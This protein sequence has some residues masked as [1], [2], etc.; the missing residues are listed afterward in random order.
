MS[1]LYKHF[2][3]S[4]QGFHSRLNREAS[5][6]EEQLQLRE[7]LKD[8][9]VDHPRLSVRQI[10]F[11][12]K[13]K[14]MGRDEFELYCYGYGLKIMRKRS[15][16][17]TTDSRG[18][19]RFPNLLLEIDFIT[20]TNQVWVTD[21]TYFRLIEQMWYLTF[22]LDLY[23]RSIVGYSASTSLRAENT[24]LP[25]LIMAKKNRKRDVFNN[26]IVHSDGGGQFYCRE[27]LKL[28][29][30]ANIRNSMCE[31]VYGNTH[32]E[33]INGT[34]KNDYLI[35]YAPANPKE[36]HQKLNKAVYLYNNQRPHKSL[37]RYS[38]IAFE[39]ATAKGT[40]QKTWKVCKKVICNTKK[41]INISI[42]D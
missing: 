42:E 30:K 29:S 36:L 37:G 32:A 5:R 27:Y 38:P 18:V 25:A 16:I 33:R 14:T 2:R 22:I 34:I 26:L 19:N 10:Y 20:S 31:N 7:I 15:Y 17:K 6:R 1:A 41:H 3:I 35:P 13:P 4:K 40:L 23:S 9:R 39:K 21:I 8:I 11:M 24:S 28:T 12:I